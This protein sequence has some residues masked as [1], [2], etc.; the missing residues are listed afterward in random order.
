MEFAITA[1]YNTK[2]NEK[3][4]RYRRIGIVHIEYR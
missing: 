4:G 1:V 3:M 2:V